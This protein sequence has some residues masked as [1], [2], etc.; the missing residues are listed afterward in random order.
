MAEIMFAFCGLNLQAMKRTFFQMIVIALGILMILSCK[1]ENNTSQDQTTPEQAPAA[2][3]PPAAPGSPQAESGDNNPNTVA[4]MPWTFLTH[5]LFQ[6]RATVVS[7]RVGENPKEGYWL[8]FKENGTY[9]YGIWGEQ[10]GSGTWTYDNDT[11]LLEMT[12]TSGPDKPSEWQVKHKEDNVVLLGT[13]RFGN[14]T[15]QENWVRRATLPDQN[16][17]PK[18]ADDEE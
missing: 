1:Q 7:G 16:A 6:N 9:D 12:P 17:K 18:S 14:N 13:A 3:S 10:K 4:N 8:D 15:N 11:R 5:Q 2:V